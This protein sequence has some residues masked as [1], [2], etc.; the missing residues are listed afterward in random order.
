MRISLGIKF[1]FEKI[2]LNF[3]TKFAQKGYSR[4]KIEKVNIAIEFCILGLV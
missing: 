4:S 2:L 1:R 3:W